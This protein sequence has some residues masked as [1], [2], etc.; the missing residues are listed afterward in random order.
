MYISKIKGCG[1]TVW[2]QG[3]TFISYFRFCA[4]GH[5]KLQNKKPYIT[6]GTEKYRCKKNPG[7]D[8]FFEIL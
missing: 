6:K 3:N 4:M 1:L 2:Q 8:N 7:L 5:L